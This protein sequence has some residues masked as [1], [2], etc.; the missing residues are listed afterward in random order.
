MIIVLNGEKQ[1]IG[2]Q[3]FHILHE[4]EFGRG[5]C[6]IVYGGTYGNASNC[7]VKRLFGREEWSKKGLDYEMLFSYFKNELALAW[8]VLYH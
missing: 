1:V 7:V 4:N 8:Y 2:P 5:S 6:G 3:D